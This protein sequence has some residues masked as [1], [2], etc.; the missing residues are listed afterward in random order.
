[1]VSNTKGR[2]PTVLFS[3]IQGAKIDMTHCTLTGVSPSFCSIIVCRVRVIVIQSF[4]QTPVNYL[5]WP[6][7]FGVWHCTADVN[8][9]ANY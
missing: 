9:G 5:F 2:Q 1:M 4:P 6:S 7:L 8:L 3:L